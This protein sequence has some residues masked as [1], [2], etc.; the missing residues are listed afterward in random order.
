MVK[1]NTVIIE[2]RSNTITANLNGFIT[3]THLLFSYF[4]LK[5]VYDFDIYKKIHYNELC[6]N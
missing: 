5:Y 2:L 3:I 1:A 6:C 4:I